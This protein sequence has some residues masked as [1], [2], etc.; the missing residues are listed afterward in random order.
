MP[1]PGKRKAQVNRLPQV[2]HARLASPAAAAAAAAEAGAAAAAA[3]AVTA[4]S[5][6]SVAATTAAAAATA[7]GPSSQGVFGYA[8]HAEAVARTADVLL[9]AT[10]A[11]EAA[12]A[13]HDLHLNQLN[14]IEPML[15]DQLA[16]YGTPALSAAP[17]TTPA[18]A[19]AAAPGSDTHVID[20]IN[21][22][23]AAFKAAAEGARKQRLKATADHE[24]AVRNHSEALA[25][26]RF[27][28]FDAHARAACARSYNYV[29]VA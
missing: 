24:A 7:A 10:A 23:L 17:P 19:G 6:V 27:L 21:I 5:T 8:A 26:Y 1:N 29:H 15:L 25:A 4:A 2:Q 13:Q 3:D 22:S 14:T 28:D 18:E 11:M 16:L 12:V 9:K 20:A